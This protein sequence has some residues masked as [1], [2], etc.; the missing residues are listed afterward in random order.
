MGMAINMVSRFWNYMFNIHLLY[1][2]GDFHK[3]T[4][5]YFNIAHM[6]YYVHQ[7]FCGRKR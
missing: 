3:I 1:N 5:L 2:T 4:P 7:H 6:P